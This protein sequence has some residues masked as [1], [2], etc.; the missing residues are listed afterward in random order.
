MQLSTTWRDR[1]ATAL[2][3]SL[4]LQIVPA[5][6]R[7]AG[8]P[9]LPDG[10]LMNTQDTDYILSDQPSRKYG[11]GLEGRGSGWAF[12]GAAGQGR[13]YSLD[14]LPILWVE[15][16]FGPHGPPLMPSMTVSVERVG[17]DFLVEERKSALLRWGANPVVGLVFR[18]SVWTLGGARMEPGQAGELHG[19]YHF[20]LGGM[21]V[22]VVGLNLHPWAQPGWAAESDV[23]K[24]AEIKILGPEAGVACRIDRRADGSPEF[25][26]EGMVRLANGVGLGFRG[27]PH[28]GSMG[29]ILVLKSGGLNLETSH[30]VHPALG[31][32][33]R[34]LL[35]AGDPRVSSR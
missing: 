26:F 31:V 16:G 27:D 14:E 3:A 22:G 8:V 30:L 10:W 12:W 9:G 28:T 17:S 5:L 4:L 2:L 15:V 34:F 20:G 32:T 13:L 25:S 24:V 6:G 29:G 23:L 33:N 21:V 35:G 18:S 19:R 1:F 7:A 11:G